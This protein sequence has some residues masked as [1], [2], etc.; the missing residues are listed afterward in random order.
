MQTG[1]DHE[2]EV[3]KS[4][5]KGILKVNISRSVDIKFK[6]STRHV[7]R[8]F[9]RASDLQE[10]NSMGRRKLKQLIQ[11]LSEIC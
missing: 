9:R 1:L 3:I 5:S 11:K 10:L 6:M 4:D 7:S 8:Y 2:L